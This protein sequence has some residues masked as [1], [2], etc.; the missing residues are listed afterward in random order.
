MTLARSGY[1][2]ETVINFNEEES[3]GG[4]RSQA[5][6]PKTLVKM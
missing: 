3:T 6:Y 1:E 5:P 4:G 2:A